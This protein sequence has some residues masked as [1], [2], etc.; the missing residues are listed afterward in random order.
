MRVVLQFLSVPLSVIC[1]IIQLAVVGGI[2]NGTM[3][4]T[5]GLLASGVVLVLEYGIFWAHSKKRGEDHE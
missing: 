5:T 2:E 3:S 1:L 4:I